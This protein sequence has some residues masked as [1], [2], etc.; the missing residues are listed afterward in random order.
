MKYQI[1]NL[2]HFKGDRSIHNSR[3]L[4][5]DGLIVALVV[6]FYALGV[7]G[8]APDLA[9][10]DSSR[11]EMRGII[12]RYTAD[13]GSL[14]RSYPVELSQGRQTRFKQF[15]SDWLALIGKM[16]F[17]AMSLDGKVD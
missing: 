12:E 14:S 8:N 5:I 4:L 1:S 17:D 6:C 10:I 7:R 3:V 2:Q 13:R 11:S 16:N 9:D 15:Y